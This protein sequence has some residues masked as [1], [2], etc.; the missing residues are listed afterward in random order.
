MRQLIEGTQQQ[1]TYLSG[2]H[3]VAAFVD[4]LL[5]LAQLARWSLNSFVRHCENGILISWGFRCA[6]KIGLDQLTSIQRTASE[7]RCVAA[8]W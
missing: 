3:S 1:D 7:V 8:S 6:K 5:E 4:K 2:T